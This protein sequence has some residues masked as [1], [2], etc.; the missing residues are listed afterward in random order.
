[1]VLGYKNYCIGEFEK[2][3]F[4]HGGKF[5]FLCVSV[6]ECVSLETSSLSDRIF[7]FFFQRTCLTVSLTCCSIGVQ[8]LAVSED[9]LIFT[10]IHTSRQTKYMGVQ[11]SVYINTQAIALK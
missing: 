9:F 1:M 3:F 11:T 10:F 8:I 2:Y 5:D 4:F 6:G 7:I